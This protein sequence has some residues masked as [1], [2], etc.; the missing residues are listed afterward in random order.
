MSSDGQLIEVDREIA[1]QSVTIKHMLDDIGEGASN[2]A[3]VC[4]C[5]CVCLLLVFG[6]SGSI[7][8]IVAGLIVVVGVF[9]FLDFY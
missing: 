7:E 1:E 3:C 9:V 8:V 5:V 4:V 2:F 6:F